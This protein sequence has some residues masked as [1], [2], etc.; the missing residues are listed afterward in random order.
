VLDDLKL[1]HVKLVQLCVDNQSAIN[2]AKNQISHGRS[3]H[4]ETKFHF[5]REQVEKGKLEVKHCN[6][7]EQVADIFT[8]PLRLDK[9]EELRE[10]KE[11]CWNKLNLEL[12]Y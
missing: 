2:L 1:D 4:I 12:V 3:K 10:L 9:F 11:E 7:K 5:L 6:T 8:K